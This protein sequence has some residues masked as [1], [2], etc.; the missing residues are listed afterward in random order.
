MDLDVLLPKL[1]RALTDDG[2]LLVWRN[3]FGDPDAPVTQFREHVEQIVRGRGAPST[4]AVDPEDAVATAAALTSTDLFV[5]KEIVTYRWSIELD[6]EGIRR[7]FTTFSDWTAVEVNRAADAARGLGGTVVEHYVS[8]LI[9]LKPTNHAACRHAGVLERTQAPVR[10]RQ[11]ESTTLG[12][13]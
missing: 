1:R 13:G 6:H 8:W 7:L 9:I 5:A 12:A 4:P 10:L 2:V 3:V 11:P